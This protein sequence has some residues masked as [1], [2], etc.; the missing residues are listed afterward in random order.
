[1]ELECVSIHPDYRFVTPEFIREAHAA[2]LWVFVYTPNAPDLVRALFAMGV[3]AL[4][5]DRLDLISPGL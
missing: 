2:G 4:C 1:M 3:D 5:T